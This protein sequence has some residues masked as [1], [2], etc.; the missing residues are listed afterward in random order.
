[1]MGA[2]SIRG[3]A[4]VDS[5]YMR[6]ILIESMLARGFDVIGQVRID[7]RLYEEPPKRKKGARPRESYGR[8][9][10]SVLRI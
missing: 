4:L 6:R 1:M 5:C 8:K 9:Y 10:T 2:H 3:R 7:T